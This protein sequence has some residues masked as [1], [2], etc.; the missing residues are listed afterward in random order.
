MNCG[1]LEINVKI[2]ACVEKLAEWGK[3]LTGN[4]DLRIRCCKEVLKELKGERC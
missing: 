2:Q 1:S 4:F 3:E